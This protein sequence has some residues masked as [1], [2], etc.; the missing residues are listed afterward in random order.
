MYVG[1]VPPLGRLDPTMLRGAAELAQHYGDASL[2]F[3]PWQ[4][5][6]LPNIRTQDAALVI[7]QLAGAGFPV[8]TAVEPCAL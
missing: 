4:S 5:L 3:T 2:R 1:A 8:S 6:L 7:R